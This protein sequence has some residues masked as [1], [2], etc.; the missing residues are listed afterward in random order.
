M[1]L[2]MS[3]FIYVL[4]LFSACSS[5]TYFTED[6]LRDPGFDWKLLEVEA[7]FHRDSPDCFHMK[8][9]VTVYKWPAITSKGNKM[10]TTVTI[11]KGMELDTQLLLS[12]H[13]PYGKFLNNLNKTS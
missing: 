13:D 9:E 10:N 4:S 8:E 1:M 7:H 5:L 6:Q 2:K 3:V 11:V 12:E